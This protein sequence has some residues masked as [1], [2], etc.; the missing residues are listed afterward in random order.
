MTM[1]Y[2]KVSK[3]RIKADPLALLTTVRMI[4]LTFL[5]F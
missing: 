1:Q 3:H 2:V 5:A 4:S